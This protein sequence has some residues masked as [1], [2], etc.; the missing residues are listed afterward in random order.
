M[1]MASEV[2]FESPSMGIEAARQRFQRIVVPM[3]GQIYGKTNGNAPKEVDINKDNNLLINGTPVG[4]WRLVSRFE[5]HGPMLTFQYGNH[6]RMVM[7]GTDPLDPLTCHEVDS[8]CEF[9][10][11]STDVKYIYER[12]KMQHDSHTNPARQPHDAADEKPDP[13]PARGAHL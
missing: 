12:P 10:P 7:F 1:S 8:V 11:W 13:K 9:A 5:V 2:I 6:T 4:D 3:L